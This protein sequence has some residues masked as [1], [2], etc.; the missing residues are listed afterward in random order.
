MKK[1]IA[2]LSLT[3]AITMTALAGCGGSSSSSSGGSSAPAETKAAAESSAPASADTSDAEFVMKIGGQWSD[4]SVHSRVI[5]E[6]LIPKVEEYSG[7]RIKCEFYGNNAIG[8]ELD[9][10]SQLQMNTLQFAT[11]SDQSATIDQGNMTVLYLPYLFTSPEHWDAV[12]DGEIGAKLTENLPS[13]GVRVLGFTDNG[14][15]EIT[16]NKPINSAADMKGLKM[17]VT[18]SDMYIA[19]FEALGCSCQ[20]MTLAD[21]YTALE[22][23][24][25]DGQDNAYNTILNAS[26]NDVQDYLCNSDHVLGTLY[27]AVSET[28]YQSLPA[29]LQEALDKAVKEACQWERDEY[30][31][32]TEEDHQ[33][34]LDAGMQE[35]NPDKQSF[36]DATAVVY[37]NFLAK[38][39]EL[40]EV[41]DQI[42]AMGE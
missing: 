30:R 23:G 1:R 31:R 20:A 8:N 7:G 9:Q 32:L 35:T 16:S 2:A 39:P 36:I 11:L 41:V 21:A 38:Y 28:W 37:D 19:I 17:R 27:Q 4:S 5:T 29:D 42:K 24:T 18:S 12:V 3:L 25:C 13:Q 33:A 15:R 40:A 34:L 22:T 26:L 6:A 10:L 14:Y